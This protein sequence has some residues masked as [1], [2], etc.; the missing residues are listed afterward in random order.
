M[1]KFTS[2]MIDDYAKKLLIGLTEEENKM[3]AD[4]FAYIDQNIEVV[5]QIPGI[6]NVE[7]MTYALDDFEVELREDIAE[8]S[9][10]IKDLLSNAD[11][12]DGREIEVVKVVGE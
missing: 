9:V 6:E 1:N 12:T 3:V 4:E 11:G 8:E 7:P 2:E 10:P 5:S